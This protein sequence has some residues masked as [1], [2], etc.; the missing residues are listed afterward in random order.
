MAGPHRIL[1]LRIELR[2]ARPPVWRRLLAPSWL[3]LDDLHVA[4]QCAM[5]WRS[6]HRYLFALGSDRY[7]LTQGDEETR[8]EAA[9]FTPLCQLGLEEGS[10]LLY[11]YDFADHW[12]HDLVVEA[13]LD[14]GA[15][16]TQPTCTGGEGTCP[17]EESGG[18]RA[19]LGAPGR[20]REAGSEDESAEP[21]DPARANAALEAAFGV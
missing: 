4:I 20:A 16:P 19:G 21:F 18:V 2:G 14:P 10:R 11:V 1:Q 12:R 7:A 8:V 5:G 9:E 17:S 13:T 15:G 6:R 3:T